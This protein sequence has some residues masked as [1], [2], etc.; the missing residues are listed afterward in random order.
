MLKDVETF[1]GSTGRLAGREMLSPY[2]A[3]AKLSSG[4][5]S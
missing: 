3:P 4:K 2:E 5:N 1:G